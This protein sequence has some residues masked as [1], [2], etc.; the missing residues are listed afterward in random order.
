MNQLSTIE[1]ALVDLRQGKFVILVDDESREN[2]GDLVIA[3][4][5]ITP[6]AINFMA[7]YGRGLICLPLATEYVER[8]NLPLMVKNNRSKY[9]TAFTVSIGAA[10][11][12]TTGISA[13]DRASTVLAAIA[14]DATPE[15]IVM[16]G[17]IFPLLAKEGGVLVRNG[18]TEGGVDL[19]KLAGLKPAAVLCEI[20]NDDGTM[21]RISDLKF[22]SK[23]HDIKIIS[24]T[25]LITYR[26]KQECLIDEMATAKL[27]IQHQGEFK[28]KIFK[29]RLDNIE[30]VALVRGD[31]SLDQPC[32]VRLHSECLTGDIFGSKRCDCGGQLDA[33]LA[34]LSK[35]GGVLLYIRQQEGRGIGLAN[36]IRAYALQEQGLD[37]VEANHR[38]GFL[39][40]QRDYGIGAQILQQMNI[41]KIKLMTNNPHKV[42]EMQR[43]GIE[44]VGREP[45]QIIPT[46]ENIAYLKTK[47]DKLGHLLDL[48]LKKVGQEG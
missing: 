11:G 6:E 25:D 44:I 22:F 35:E 40:D 12:I 39:A 10:N 19:A 29:S 5:K 4:E 28:I 13:A 41:K 8:L 34:K 47:R 17:H 27:P 43:Y 15:D 26:V 21:A 33:A 46:K 20:M 3:A 9:Q 38:L 31:I 37:T 30:H 16:P 42:D 1:S 18:H 7:K 45:L 36:K 24:I 48:N 2:E 23:K 32:L 14:D